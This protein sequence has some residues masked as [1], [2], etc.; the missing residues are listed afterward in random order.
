MADEAGEDWE[1]NFPAIGDPHHEIRELLKQRGLLEVFYNEDCG[2]LRDREWASHPKGY[3]QPAVIA[4][5]KSGRVLYR[6]RCVPKYSNMSGAGARPE[7]RYTW[8]HV[9]AALGDSAD[10]EF[11][12]SPTLGA[13]DLSWPRFLLIL[14]AHGWF[15]RPKAFPLA[16]A[17]DKSRVSP[18]AMMPRVYAFLA[19]WAVALVLFPA[20]WVGVAA[21][22]WLMAL[23]PGLIE[24]HRQFQN[25]PDDY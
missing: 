23:T 20:V 13:V 12:Q 21:A 4:L 16:R 9:K 2:H 5:S 6:W 14:T 1:F 3:Y 18:G 17:D 11:D 10:A 22:I 15:I 25:E 19:L 7:A 8:D 24:I